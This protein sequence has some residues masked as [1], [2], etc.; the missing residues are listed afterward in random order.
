MEL[1]IRGEV[2]VELHRGL[3]ATRGALR[4]LREGAP[5]D[6]LNTA[7]A[8]DG[9]PGAL[10]EWFACLEALVAH[11][12]VQYELRRGTTVLCALRS[13][14]PHASGVLL[15]PLRRTS[16]QLSR[17]AHLRPAR[18]GFVLESPRSACRVELLHPDALVWLSALSAPPHRRQAGRA[19]PSLFVS[20]L[21]AA[22]M[23]VR[24]GAAAR[25]ELAGWSFADALMHSRSRLGRHDEPYGATYPLAAER[26]PAP[27][28]AP[29][30][31]GRA[32]TL[33]RPSLARLTASDQPFT[34]VLE[35]RRSRRDFGA[36]PLP[37][38]ALGEFL[39]RAAHVQRAM[40][41]GR[42]STGYPWTR[43]PSPSGGASHSLELYLAVRR[44]EGL[45]PGIFHYDPAR[46]RLEPLP[47]SADESAALLEG[48]RAAVPGSGAPAV[49]VILASRFARVNWK[50]ESI[51]YATVLKDVGALLQTMY[52]VATAMDLAPCAVG[53]GDAERFATAIGRSFFE[54]TSV[55]EFLL[56]T[57]PR[58]RPRTRRRRTPPGSAR[59]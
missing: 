10:A 33:P 43:R 51:A 17:F 38:A 2:R 26:P 11:G 55:G 45:E 35:A 56:G 12:G 53:G 28:T 30:R 41:R 46:H 5:L 29:A 39:F 19:A 20:L 44:C 4:R 48:A 7:I 59:A 57:R 52:L 37:L 8:A 49:L 47:D 31:R 15:T 18:K 6:A 40:P 27:A 54:E 9:H 32:I 50:Y 42:G 22:D 24:R 58:S 25:A 13:I 3:Q 14:G 34:R 23:L 21:H 36:A 1:A 16:W